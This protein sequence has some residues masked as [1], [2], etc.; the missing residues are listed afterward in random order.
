MAAPPAQGES[1]SARRQNGWVGPFVRR[2][3]WWSAFVLFLAAVLGLRLW[4]GWRVGA[5]LAARR[6][7]ARRRGEPLEASG[8][9]VEQV[10]DADNAWV[11]I[12]QAARLD[13]GSSAP[14]NGQLEYP[15]YPPFGAAWEQAAAASEA[16]NAGVFPLARQARGRPR[17]QLRQGYTSPLFSGTLA[18]GLTDSRKLANTLTDG[19][20]H[21]HLRG[22]DAEAVERL[23]DT[24]HV[25][26]S[27][28][29]DGTI[30][31]QLIAIGITALDNERTQVIAPGLRVSA[32]TRPGIRGLIAEL[33]DERRA[34]EGLRRSLVHER[35]G[36]VE[37]VQWES[38]GTWVIRPLAERE[39]V[40]T[41]AD[42]AVYAAAARTADAETARRILAG[43]KERWRA[44]E[45]EWSLRQG[46]RPSSEVP[47]YSLWYRTQGSLDRMF[48]Q[49]FRSVGE[50]RVT[51]VSLAAQL[52][53]ADHGTWPG[54]LDELTPDYLP[55][56]PADPF[57]ADGRSVGYVVMKGG[58]P[59]G[60]DRPLV[61]YD[62]GA[63]A[64]VALD[65]EPMYGWQYERRPDGTSS[66]REI[67][68][69]RDLAR[70]M[71]ADR[72]FERERRAEEEARRTSE[73]A[74]EGVD[75]HPNQ[76]DAPRDDAQK[77]DQ[78]KK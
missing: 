24:L 35:V 44:E 69:Y 75:D 17:S 27:V 41:Y 64:A 56:L 14:A 47:R 78:P 74:S 46:G 61:Y 22:D 21:R 7:E 77:Q 2:R 66:K 15:G 20:L 9:A 8:L 10:P 11:L 19:V 31:S 68:Q 30:I 62:A 39:M 12:R 57:H 76:P 36:T 23:R 71:P 70:W 16:A 25:A 43:P 40:R 54:R 37:L 53:R 33:L 38:A 32:D 29:Q 28:H 59:G 50:R 3:P 58:L 1:A 73:G 6:E 72:R 4:W 42:A 26:D 51:A 52:Y 18:A 45:F 60:A 63:T 48:E 55:A 5:D 67:R 13:D 65:D 34:A 49:W